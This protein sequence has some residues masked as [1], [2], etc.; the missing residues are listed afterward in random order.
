MKG[1]VFKLNMHPREYFDKN[2]F[3]E[4]G[5]TRRSR[6][7]DKARSKSAPSD[8]KKHFRFSSPGKRVRFSIVLFVF[9]FSSKFF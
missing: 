5:K 3:H 7:A 9:L 8:N 1:G 6:S 2:P 4:D